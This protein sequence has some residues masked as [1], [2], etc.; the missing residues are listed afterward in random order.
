MIISLCCDLQSQVKVEVVGHSIK[1]IARAY[2]A[3]CG[4]NLNIGHLKKIKNKKSYKNN[5]N[6]DSAPY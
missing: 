2:E 4:K 5:Y 3:A 1:T 6:H